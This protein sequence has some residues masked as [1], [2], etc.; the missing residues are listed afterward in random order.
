MTETVFEGMVNDVK[1]ND[2]TEYNKAVEDVIKSGKPYTATSTIKVVNKNE[3]SNANKQNP[4]TPNTPIYDYTDCFPLFGSGD[5]S[6]EQ[7]LDKI[8]A[9]SK[10]DRIA[11]VAVIGRYLDR[12]KDV[13]SKKITATEDRAWL[14]HYT[15]NVT[16][17]MD[18][19][20]T[21]TKM[22]DQTRSVIY[23]RMDTL[24]AKFLDL[25]SQLEN[26]K[27]E[28]TE[29][30]K[31]IIALEAAHDELKNVENFYSSMFKK[32]REK[33]SRIGEASN[34]GTPTRGATNNLDGSFSESK[35]TLHKLLKEIFGPDYDWDGD[36]KF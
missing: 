17:I 14:Q 29:A 15:D 36:W 31:K 22:N 1:Y 18:D 13:I 10:E 34:E 8:T 6:I 32:A 26:V 30:S 16:E 24:N 25:Q 35:D 9:G 20:K 21:Y 19:L 11:I 5:N 3:D 4:G 33:E 12:C 7:Y 23:G 27:S 2:Q 28:M